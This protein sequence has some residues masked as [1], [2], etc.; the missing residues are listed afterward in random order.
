MARG[1]LARGGVAPWAAGVTVLYTALD[2]PAP[3]FAARDAAP[4]IADPVPGRVHFDFPATLEGAFFGRTEELLA[5]G[6]ALTAGPPPRLVTIHGLGG[7]GKTTL[8][9]AAA[10]RFAYAY[11]SGAYGVSL[12]GLPSPGSI[13]AGL[14]GHLGLNPDEARDEEALLAHIS[15]QLQSSGLLLLIDNVETLAEGLRAGDERAAPLANF[16]RRG[17]PPAVTL[18]A[19]SRERLGWPLTPAELVPLSGLSPAAGAELFAAGTPDRQGQVSAEE[20]QALSARVGGHPLTLRLLAGTFNAESALSFAALLADYERHMVAAADAV[21]GSERHR[22][23]AAAHAT[24]VAALDEETRALLSGLWPWQGPFEADAA[25]AVFDAEQEKWWESPVAARLETLARRGLLQRQEET[26]S[27]T[28]AVFYQLLPALRPYARA[29]PGA[30]PAAEL[31][32]RW[33]AWQE[34]LSRYVTDHIKEGGLPVALARYGR[35]D[36]LRAIDHLDGE[37]QAAATRRAGWFAHVLGDRAAALALTERALA[38]AGEQY[39]RERLQALNNMAQVYNATGRPSEALALYEQALPIMR[40]AGDR[41]GEAATLNNMGGVYQATGRPSEALVLYEQALPLI[42]EVGDRAGEAATLNNMGGVYDATGR[43]S[44]ALALYEQALP[45]RREVGDRAGEATTLHNMGAVY[46]ATG[47]PSEALALYEQALPIRREVGDRT[48]EAATLNNMGMVYRATGRPIEALA[49]YKQA[50]PLMREVGNRAGE[51]TTLNNIGMV[52]KAT[53]RPSEALALYEQ[54]LPLMREV[55]DRAGEATTL[56]NMGG[57]YGAMGRRPE[58]LQV[59]ADTLPILQEIGHRAGNASTLG[60]MAVLLAQMGRT[61]EAVT[62]IEEALALFRAGLTHDAGGGTVASYERLLQQLRGGGSG[63][64]AANPVRAAVVAFVNA[65]SWAASRAVLEVRRDLLLTDEAEE[66]FAA[67][68]AAAQGQGAN[69]MAN[70]LT[71]HQEILRACRAQG[72][73]AMF[74]ELEAPQ[75]YLPFPVELRGEFI[76]AMRGDGAAKMALVN[77]LTALRR[78]AGEDAALR[79][80]YQAMQ[81]ALLGKSLPKAGAGLPQPY[82]GMW[83]AICEALA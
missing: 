19:T 24:S 17:L 4:Q 30:V 20:A 27:Q 8:G 57:V 70:H 1:A 73:A 64:P 5:L 23:L 67:F 47:R 82:A 61:A 51:A 77:R 62:R 53:G 41:A 59:W 78:A 25:V 34:K 10:A 29:L 75:D 3:G 72:I 18:L 63:Q 33:A 48:G 69:D 43:P 15:R 80:F 55:G 74:D 54:A 38:L 50:L 56:N 46:R 6:Q 28:R 71:R 66:A 26:F 58:A 31:L 9:R 13:L 39:P 79:S 16:L 45:I 65:E 7:Q 52:Y 68:I 21:P 36:L 11:P 60:N 14:A 2:A 40:E 22:T 37:Q 12:E 42:R 83:Q 76:D 49:H 32:R 81:D 44:E 35:E